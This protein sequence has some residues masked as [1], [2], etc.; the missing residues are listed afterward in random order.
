M[1]H[2]IPTLEEILELSD[3]RSKEGRELIARAYEFAKEA[4]QG[5]KR[6]SG[7]P[8]FQHTATVATYL[9]EVGLDASTIAAGL[10][11]DS[12]EDTGVE[13]KEIEKEFGSEVAMLVDSVTKLG[14]VRYRGLER[15]A[16][17]LRK[18]FAATASDVRVLIVKLMDRLHNART[19]EHVPEHKRE[20]IAKETLEIYAPIAFRLGMGILQKDL[21]DAAFPYAYPEEYARVQELLKERKKEMEKRL[22]RAEKDLK[23]ALGEVGIRNFRTQARAKGVY[24]L[25]K[26]LERKEWDISKIHDVLALRVILG[27]VEDC[28]RVFGIVHKIWTPMPGR[29]KDYIS[30]PKL[31]GYQSIHTTV[32]TGDGGLLEIQIRTEE[33]HREA[34]YGY[35]AHMDYKSQQ[36][37]K[38]GGSKL[39]WIWQFF[40][41]KPDGHREYAPRRYSGGVYEGGENAPHWVKLLAEARE[42]EGD[43]EYLKDLKEDFFSHRIFVFTPRGDVI[44]LPV[45]AT[46]IDFAYSLHSGI[47]EHV[48]SAKI[49]G[50]LVSLDTAIESG[51]TVEV[52]TKQSAHPTRKWLDAARTNLAKR[53]IRAYLSEQHKAKR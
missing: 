2:K 30:N 22:E 20:R 1:S 9:A 31:N 48:S 8:Y 14:T 10:L 23:R 27:S 21:E 38:G 41:K 40:S 44:D 47:G 18:L 24:S 36:Q 13:L 15:H 50:K 37:Q 46:P 33:M 3:I 4:H 29:I 16:E 7:A 11:H 35:A 34:Q 45:G 12:V 5:Q 32:H 25:Y 6:Y 42:A 52:E 43:E 53:K 26:K 51:E 39:N 19:L 17:S 28:Y 49:N